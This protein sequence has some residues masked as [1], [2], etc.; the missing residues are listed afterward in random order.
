MEWLALGSAFCS[1]VALQRLQL[2]TEAARSHRLAEVQKKDLLVEEATPLSSLESKKKLAIAKWEKEHNSKCFYVGETIN[3]KLALEIQKYFMHPVPASVKYIDLIMHSGGGTSYYAFA[4]LQTLNAITHLPKR[5]II[6]FQATSSA[7]MIAIC[8]DQVYLSLN[9]TL[10]S[11]DPHLNRQVTATSAPTM[12]LTDDMIAFCSLNANTLTEQLDLR[13][14]RRVFC[15]SRDLFYRVC[16]RHNREH[17]WRNFTLGRSHH[18]PILSVQA[19][20]YGL[21]HVV[22]G[23]NHTG[24]DITLAEVAEFADAVIPA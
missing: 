19:H 2:Q 8:C 23:P 24:T 11:I 15:E 6:P 4:I 17:L 10:G 16:R 21:P 22:L 18:L 7:T 14:G 12:D 20:E 3:E 13:L 5:A 1:L 9:A